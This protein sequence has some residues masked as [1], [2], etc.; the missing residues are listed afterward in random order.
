MWTVT[1]HKWMYYIYLGHI[2]E[3]NLRK[4]SAIFGCKD[5]NDLSLDE[6]RIDQTLCF[7]DR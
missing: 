4:I 3:Y 7:Q 2:G 5:S 6:E 1:S